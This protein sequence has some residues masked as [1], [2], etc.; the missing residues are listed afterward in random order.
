MAHNIVRR[1]RR[2]GEEITIASRPNAA[3]AADL[4]DTLNRHAVGYTFSVQTP[5]E[6]AAADPAPDRQLTTPAET[7]LGD[8]AALPTD[9]NRDGV[10][11]SSTD[12]PPSAYRGTEG[13]EA[14]VAAAVR[15]EMESRTYDRHAYNAEVFEEGVADIA[16]AALA[17]ADA[18]AAGA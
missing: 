15:R 8:A 1:S 12:A 11:Q 2:T 6:A 14:A 9:A 4:V 13:R 3:D 18:W 7:V 16:R 10:G 17:A 5:H